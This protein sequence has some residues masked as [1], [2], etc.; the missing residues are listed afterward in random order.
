M[1]QWI[2]NNF[3][4]I[5]KTVTIGAIFFV[6]VFA[7]LSNV[8]TAQAQS[9]ADQNSTVNQGLQVIEQP[10]G[11]P[12]TDIRTI[13]ANIIRAA[14][15]LLGIIVVVLMI[16]AGYLWMTAG[17][18][19]EQIA[20]AKKV[21]RNAVIGLVVI[22][23]AYAIVAFIFRMLG[24][25]NGSGQGGPVGSAPAVHNFSG[26]GGLGQI[27][28]DHYPMRNQT[29]IP[30]N[31]KIIISFF[32]P[33]KIET[34]AVSSTNN[35][36]GPGSCGNIGP[37]MNWETD[38]SKMKIGSDEIRISKVINQNGVVTLEP[39]TGAA[40]IAATSTVSGRSGY[41]TI[42]I[43]P[44]DQP[45]KKPGL[46]SDTE[47]VTYLVHLGSSLLKDDPAND[48]PPL[49]QS[50]RVGNNYYEWNFTCNTKID[51][52]PPYVKDVFPGVSA[53]ETKDSVIQIEFNEALDPSGIQ[54]DFT[55]TTVSGTH[56]YTLQG[57]NVYLKSDHSSLPL[58]TMNLTNGFTVLEFT[59]SFACAANACGDPKFCLP[60]CDNGGACDVVTQ[61]WR[62]EDI[63][64]D[65][66]QM[67]LKAGVAFNVN[68]FEAIPFSGVMDAA[69]N[70]LDGNRDLRVQISSNTDTLPVFED[71]K[72]PDNYWWNFT[73][74]D[75][76]D[77]ISPYLN[78]VYP[79]L[80]AANTP[81]S[82]PL[83]MIFSKRMRVDPLYKI[84]I[85]ENPTPAA[86]GDN[87]PIWK[88]PRVY[89]HSVT[90]TVEIEHGLFLDG[91]K[92]YY[93][94]SVPSAVQD[95]HFNC[96]YAGMGPKVKSPASAD[97]N[98]GR[99]NSLNCTGIGDGSNCCNVTSSAENPAVTGQDYCCF[100]AVN[101]LNPGDS[102][103][104]TS[105]AKCFEYLKKTYN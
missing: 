20:Q 56:Y 14:L 98:L 60:V 63:K 81:T 102:N 83:G 53:Q 1:L 48:N 39:I 6:T 50:T 9:V 32:V 40:L 70:A 28:K 75:E 31:T 71:W 16:Y 15:G 3:S 44:Y 96:F 34:F 30:R 8:S 103:F 18:N 78:E 64:G 37:N 52:T 84:T 23:S 80:G 74:K 5:S 12:S 72:K 94:P 21:L 7:F 57:N 10:L 68:S 101:K 65:K 26:S 27:V 42:V 69:G 35:N 105:S 85:D 77:L 59:P 89:F 43:R 82:A 91:I 47:N 95:V 93:Y 45:G 11:L 49:F 92:Q 2:K 99:Q 66:F 62:G 54:G 87:T 73:L 17:G 33:V 86:R 36:A 25:S 29:D 67:L 61:N 104:I 41:F 51:R 55:S 76:L 58:G 46:G 24:V 13:I 88:V 19:E 38:C 90:T 79:D 22:L 4:K 97:Y 100:G